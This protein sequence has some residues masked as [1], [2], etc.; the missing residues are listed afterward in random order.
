MIAPLVTAAIGAVA[1]AVLVGVAALIGGYAWSRRLLRELAHAPAGARPVVEPPPS[2]DED[3]HT[4]DLLEDAALAY[5][6]VSLAQQVR[7]SG[8][9]TDLLDV[10]RRAL[11]LALELQRAAREHAAYV[12]E[13][14][15]GAVA[16]EKE[17]A[18]G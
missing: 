13:L 9:L 5:G 4:I 8:S 2:V 10:D 16:A 6:R 12:D 17:V 14:V 3:C 11:G 1:G 7:R 18:R 15:V